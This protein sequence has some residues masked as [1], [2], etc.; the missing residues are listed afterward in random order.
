M[1]SASWIV[2]M[3][4]IEAQIAALRAAYATAAKNYAPLATFPGERERQV[5]IRSG[6]GGR[7]LSVAHRRPGYRAAAGFA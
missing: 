2:S 5:A 3:R 7:L 1:L 4:S 6:G